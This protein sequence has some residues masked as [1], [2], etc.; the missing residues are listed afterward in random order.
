MEY[1]QQEFL[2]GIEEVVGYAHRV[3]DQGQRVLQP[4]A[5]F[6]PPENPRKGNDDEFDEIPNGMPRQPSNGNGGVVYKPREDSIDK[7]L[8]DR[9]PEHGTWV[10]E[11]SKRSLSMLRGR[12]EWSVGA[13]E[14]NEALAPD[15]LDRHRHVLAPD[16][17]FGAVFA[18]H[19]IMS[20]A[21]D[22]ELNSWREVAR[23]Y[24]LQYPDMDDI[25]RA[26]NM[27]AEAAVQRVF[28]W[29]RDWG[30]IKRYVQEQRNVIQELYEEFVFIP[31][32]GVMEWLKMLERYGVRCVLCAKMPGRMMEKTIMEVGLQR[33]FAK[34]EM[35]TI[36][37]E[38]DTME[39]MFLVAA[40]KVDRPPQKC[41]VF[42]DRPDAIAAAHEVSAKVVAIIGAHPAYE[43][44]SADAS[45]KN[46]G[47]LVVYNVRRL[48]SEYGH[49][50]GDR[51]TELERK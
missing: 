40:I 50:Y 1:L 30:E 23:I 22:L 13:D 2:G 31:R 17:A 47:E 39:Q 11:N 12:S 3:D 34:G 14:L 48:F 35:V 49:E 42:V 8:E 15:H 18:W 20:N 19:A 24:G 28:Y 51:L 29:S 25:I 44:K 36:E 41:V 37:D 45:V 9:V 43:V 5:V 38:F 21:R 27:P 6:L 4:S 33:Y 32:E 26:E 10:S 7:L 46:Y 16:E